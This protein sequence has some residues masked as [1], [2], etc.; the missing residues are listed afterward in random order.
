MVEAALPDLLRRAQAGQ[1]EA[2]GALFDQHHAAIFRFLWARLGERALAE[3]LTGEVFVRMLQ[4]LP[5]YQPT[6]PFRAWLYRIARNL[7]VDHYRRSAQRPTTELAAVETVAAPEADPLRLTDEALT[8]ARLRQALAGLE[9]A[10]RETLTLRFLAGYSLAE[11][12]AALDKT[13]G[14]IKA[15]QHRG[16]AALRRVLAE[17]STQVL[18]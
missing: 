15:L 3:D 13:E 8:A 11:T 7:L 5:N 17:E 12:A 4:A 14:A 16:L 18:P 1:P 9:D 2:I 6:A 10:Q